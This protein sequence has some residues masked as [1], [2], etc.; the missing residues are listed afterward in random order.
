MEV[1]VTLPCQAMRGLE[2][3]KIDALKWNLEAI[4]LANL[5]LLLL[6][7]RIYPGNF[8]LQYQVIQLHNYLILLSESIVL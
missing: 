3:L 8:V 5:F 4:L 1:I 7:S 6:T 2:F